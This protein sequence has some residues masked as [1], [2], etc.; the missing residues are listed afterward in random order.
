MEYYPGTASLQRQ[1]RTNDMLVGIGYLRAD[2]RA[3][4]QT[5][6]LLGVR[7]CHMQEQ[8]PRHVLMD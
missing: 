3:I 5:P 6:Q 8:T 1:Y 7:I 2:L 4:L